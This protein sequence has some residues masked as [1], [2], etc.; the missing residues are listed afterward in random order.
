MT[1]NAPDLTILRAKKNSGKGHWAPQSLHIWHLVHTGCSI[2]P[3]LLFQYITTY[4][5]LLSVLLD[6]SY[7]GALQILH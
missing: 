3:R 4:N 2:Y 5:R 7:S 6:V 1:Q